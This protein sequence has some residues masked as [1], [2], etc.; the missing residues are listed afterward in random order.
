[1]KAQND[2]IGHLH[3]WKSLQRRWAC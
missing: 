2:D 1:M 3:Q